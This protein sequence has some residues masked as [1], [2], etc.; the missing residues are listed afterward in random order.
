MYWIEVRPLVLRLVR[1]Q[2]YPLHLADELVGFRSV[3]AYPEDIRKIIDKNKSTARLNANAEVYS[4]V[5]LVDFDNN[6]EAANKAI[7][8]LKK[9]GWQVDVYTSGN[10]SVHLHV[11]LEP[12]L[13]YWVPK[14]QRNWVATNMPGAD[15]TFYHHSGMFRLPGTVH[16]KTGESKLLVESVKGKPLKI[17][18]T[19]IKTVLSSD[20]SRFDTHQQFV[21]NLLTNKYEGTRGTFVSCML[22]RDAKKLDLTKDDVIDLLLNWNSTKCYPPL[23]E[24]ELFTRI[25]EVW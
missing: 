9:E 4:D 25:D 18:R 23:S 8:F 13:G 2:L 20:H 15:L 11:A 10:R 21:M 7:S 24:E 1:P 3:Y 12:M 14:A 5:L 6:E 17:D 22:L 19:A 16:L